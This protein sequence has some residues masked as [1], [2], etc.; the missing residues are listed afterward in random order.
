MVS[1]PTLPLVG[2]FCWGVS[3]RVTQP[4]RSTVCPN[5]Y[6]LYYKIYD[7]WGKNKQGVILIMR[8]FKRG[9]G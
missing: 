5:N 7:I 6:G 8:E 1:T 2:V 4:L 9:D 3:S